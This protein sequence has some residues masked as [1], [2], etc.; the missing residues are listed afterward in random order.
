MSSVMCIIP[1]G[2]GSSDNNSFNSI[3]DVGKIIGIVIGSLIGFA[4]LIC[5]IVAIYSIF[6][7]KKSNSQVWAQPMSRPRPFGESIFTHPY[8]GHSQVPTQIF[9]VESQ[10]I[11]ETPPPS[12]EE[13]VRKDVRNKR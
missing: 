5:I 2:C 6:C 9:Q 3:L 10:Q 4:V 7:K 11:T 1:G 13:T 12:Y 8:N